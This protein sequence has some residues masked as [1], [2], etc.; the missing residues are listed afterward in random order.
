VGGEECGF[1]FSDTLLGC[2]LTGGG[3]R[4]FGFGGA[5][6]FAQALTGFVQG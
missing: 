6:R 1:E 3:G 4:G 2:L 5:F